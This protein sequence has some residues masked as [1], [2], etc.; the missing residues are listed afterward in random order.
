MCLFCTLI[1][2]STFFLWR[3]ERENDLIF[4]LMR[5]DVS[6]VSPAEKKVCVRD[7]ERVLVEHFGLQ[8][9]RGQ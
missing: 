8:T 2:M 7:R 5:G 1:H 9:K 4:V 6:S 3:M